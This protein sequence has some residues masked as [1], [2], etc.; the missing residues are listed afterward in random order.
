MKRGLHVINGYIVKQDRKGVWSV[1]KPKEPS[2]VIYS[3][4]TLRACR[5][6]CY[7]EGG[8]IKR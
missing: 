1:Y 6:F 4:K 5:V 8:I 2:L 7:G 3:N